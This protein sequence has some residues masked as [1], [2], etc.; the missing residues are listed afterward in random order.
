[1]LTAERQNSTQEVNSDMI[2]AEEEMTD[3]EE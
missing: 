2:I 1:M 3:L